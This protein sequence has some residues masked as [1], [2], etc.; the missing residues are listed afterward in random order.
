MWK[1]LS[2]LLSWRSLS[3]PSQGPR[4]LCAFLGYKE[5]LLGWSMVLLDLILASLGLDTRARLTMGD[6]YIFN[7]GPSGLI[8]IVLNSSLRYSTVI[9]RSLGL[10]TGGLQ[11]VSRSSGKLWFV[12]S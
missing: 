5:Q 11:S 6:T 9:F 1:F 4:F 10:L 7:A 3:S 12:W 8:V 2:Y